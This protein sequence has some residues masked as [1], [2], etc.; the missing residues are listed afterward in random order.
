V[1]TA[2]DRLEVDLWGATDPRTLALVQLRMAQLLRTDDVALHRPSDVP[3]PPGPMVADLPLWPTSDSFGEGERACL[4]FAEQFVLDVSGVTEAHRRRLGTYLGAQTAEFVVA[5]YALDY[6]LRIRTVL[7]R[8][9]AEEHGTP[10]AA[11]VA[12]ALSTAAAPDSTVVVRDGGA[13]F[14]D[15]DAL[16]RAVARLEA[17][18]AVTTELVRLRGARQHDCRVCQS[19]R[20]V[21]AL[22]AGADEALFD[23]TERYERSD[24]DESHKVALRLADVII[25]QPGDLDASLVAQVHAHFAPEQV[26][27]LVMDVMR[28]SAQKIA[29]ALAAD[30]P[31]VTSGVELYELTEQGDVV[32][33][34]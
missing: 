16:S 18:D 27:E 5:L 7:D 32:Y 4:E 3:E 14:G 21:R 9:F 17:V 30:A 10:H 31:R 28:N 1:A 6:G 23:Q 11:P 19:T 34:S 8:L 29:V 24:L 12:A 20:S 25:T 26:V 33:L 2:L 13:L 22:E 15:L